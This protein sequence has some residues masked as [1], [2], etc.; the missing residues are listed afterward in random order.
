M[1]WPGLSAGG[2]WQLVGDW[3]W[4]SQ[5]EKGSVA[6]CSPAPSSS[7]LGRLEPETTMQP[8]DTAVA[9]APS[10]GQCQGW[11]WATLG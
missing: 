7:F 9:A 11:L 6:I 5:G 2:T 8:S 1:N 10:Q 4:G 3:C